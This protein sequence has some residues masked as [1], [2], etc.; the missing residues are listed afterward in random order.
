MK[1][2]TLLS[3][4]TLASGVLLTGCGA[5]EKASNTVGDVADNVA[6]G[7]ADVVE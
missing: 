5:V 1:K 6:D 4:L 2:I 7:A 3:L